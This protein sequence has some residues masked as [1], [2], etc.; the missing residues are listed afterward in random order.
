MRAFA[1]SLVLLAGCASSPEYVARQSNWDVCRLTMGGPHSGAAE[2][3]ARARNLDCKPPVP[4]DPSPPGQRERGDTE[5][6][7]VH[8]ARAGPADANLPDRPGR[9]QPRD[10]VLLAPC[11]GE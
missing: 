3:E 6:P 11:A 8:P 5:P 1:V 7:A 10:S 9:Q 2:A 4:R